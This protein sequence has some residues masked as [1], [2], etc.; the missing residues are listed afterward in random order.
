ML[1]GSSIARTHRLA[2][3]QYGLAR[4]LNSSERYVSTWCNT[5]RRR[6]RVG[7]LSARRGNYYRL[8]LLGFKLEPYLNEDEAWK[9]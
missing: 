9:L 7:T 1:T 2:T 3:L 8:T 6:V 4:T 5:A